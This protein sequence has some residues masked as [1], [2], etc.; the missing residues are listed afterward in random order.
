[1]LL[2]AGSPQISQRQRNLFLVNRGKMGHFRTCANGTNNVVQAVP[3]VGAILATSAFWNNALYLAGW[4]VPLK[5]LVFNPSTGTF[6]TSL[7]SR[8]SSSYGFPG[9]TP[10][11]SAFE[12]TSDGILWALDNSRY[13]TTESLDAGLRSYWHTT[14]RIWAMSCGIARRPGDAA[15][16][17]VKFTVPSNV[18]FGTRTEIEIHALLL[19]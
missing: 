2:L 4:N 9:A 5:R 8:S 3:F 13:C 16:N 10:S 12:P 11:I 7:A 6:N 18:Y 1:V 14:R 17:A 15:K 19:N